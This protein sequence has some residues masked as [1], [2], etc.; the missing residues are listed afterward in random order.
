MTRQLLTGRQ[1]LNMVRGSGSDW[2]RITNKAH[3]ITAEVWLY[4][5]IGLFGTS[6]ADFAKE[7]A[8]ITAPNITVHLASMGGDVFDGIAIF[9]TLRTQPARVT[10]QID[11]MAG[12]IASVIA[13]AGDERQMVTGSQMMIHN[14][15]AIAIG[16]SDDLREFADVLDK[17]SAN[18]AGIYAERAG[19]GRKKSHF[20]ALMRDETW[21]S[22][23][24][25]ISEGLADSVIKPD[26]GATVDASV[27]S[28]EPLD[29]ADFLA[30]TEIV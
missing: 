29:M 14:A 23:A 26:T 17:Q 22:P 20:L 16:T 10:V 27:Q 1:V 15:H 18:I 5:E 3:P 7:L 9:N 25:A 24:E 28:Q 12:S 19:D 4:D 6:A 30:S 11:S 8:G 13:Q 2:Y 21:M